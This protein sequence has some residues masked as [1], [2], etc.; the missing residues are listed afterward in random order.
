MGG[1]GFGLGVTVDWQQLAG[2]SY[3]RQSI[4]SMLWNS[5]RILENSVVAATPWG[6]PIAAVRSEKIFQPATN[7]LMPELQF[8]T[9]RGRLVASLPWT[10]TRLV[11]MQWNDEEALVC[12]FAD[13]VV[14]TFSPAGEKLHF[15][16]L[17]ERIK[18]EGGIIQG[19]R[20]V[21]LE[22]LGNS[23]SLTAAAAAVVIVVAAAAVFA[24]AAAVAVAAAAAAGCCWQTG[25]VLS[26]KSLLAG[27]PP[28]HLFYHGPPAAPPLSGGPFI[29]A[30]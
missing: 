17:G 24:V 23:S 7:K 25:L 28:Q 2:V 9:A 26:G 14:R 3:R 13:S 8:F 4:F 15:F 16:S 18:S 19:L 10:F 29:G 11:T 20:C 22:S 5:P 30:P 6:G 1:I 27:A 21:A 12:V